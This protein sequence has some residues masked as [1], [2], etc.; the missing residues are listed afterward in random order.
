MRSQGKRERIVSYIVLGIYLLFLVW[1]ILFKLADSVDKIPSMRGINL[2]PFH[3]DQ[4]SGT[5]LHFTEVMENVL[6][7]IPAGFYFTALR[8]QRIASGILSCAV[9]S[10]VFEIV[11]WIFALGASDITDLITNTVGGAAGAVLFLLTKKICKERQM[12]VVN[13]IGIALEGIFIAFFAILIIA[14]R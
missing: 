14:N 1:L 3:Y 11:Q 10:L 13:T 5:R 9:L 7:F 12:R 2:I 4:F 6:V 8:R